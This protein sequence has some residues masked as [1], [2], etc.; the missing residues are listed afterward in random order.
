MSTARKPALY[1]DLIDSLAEV[2]RNGQGQIGAWRARSGVW[3]PHINAETAP[4]QHR[5]NLLLERLTPDE[6]FLGR[7]QGDWDWSEQ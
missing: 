1:R 2:C 7:L 3:N 6:H 4:E 5:M